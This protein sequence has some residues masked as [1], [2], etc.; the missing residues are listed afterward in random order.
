LTE[1]RSSPSTPPQ[2]Y[3]E[4]RR[5]EAV[6]SPKV[7]NHLQ[8]IPKNASSPLVASPL[9]G[10]QIPVT[11]FQQ[12][13]PGSRVR[14]KAVSHLGNSHSVILRQNIDNYENCSSDSEVT[15][16][17]PKNNSH[18]RPNW[19]FNA[20][21]DKTRPVSLPLH[22]NPSLK[23]NTHSTNLSPNV[24]LAK[25]SCRPK[26]LNSASSNQSFDDFLSTLSTNEGVEESLVCD[27]TFLFFYIKLF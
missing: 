12:H 19:S 5:S 1:D 24:A 2:S 20:T 10:L 9:I 14:K 8:N 13:S 11:H 18:I 4:R 25:N 22:Q 17:P 23:N 7:I 27:V 15:A 3:W 6:N 16:K 21:N 26:S